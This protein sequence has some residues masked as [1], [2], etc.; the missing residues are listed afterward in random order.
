MS[1]PEDSYAQLQVLKSYYENTQYDSINIY[2]VTIP[3]EKFKACNYTACIYY[4]LTKSGL[5]KADFINI[6]IQKDISF[7]TL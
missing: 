4:S 3:H 2:M 7:P 6:S 5:D 1:E